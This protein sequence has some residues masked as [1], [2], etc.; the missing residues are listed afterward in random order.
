MLPLSLPFLPRYANRAADRIVAPLPGPAT[1]G[2]PGG[3]APRFRLLDR[4]GIA[5]VGDYILPGDVYI[6]MQRPSNT[7][8][9]LPAANM[10]DSF[11]R[12]G[13]GW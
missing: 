10:P 11:Y 1:K 8:D 12:C 13:V 7:R 9:P 6:N 3:V 4:D 2:A 5:C